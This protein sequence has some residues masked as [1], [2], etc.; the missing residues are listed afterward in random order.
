MP[1][2]ISIKIQ[3]TRNDGTRMVRLIIKIFSLI[4]KYLQ[5]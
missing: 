2:K 4:L 5:R 1:K 3:D